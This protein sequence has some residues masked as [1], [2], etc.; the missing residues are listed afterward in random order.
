[1]YVHVSHEI[2]RCCCNYTRVNVSENKAFLLPTVTITLTNLNYFYVKIFFEILHEN[3]KH[4]L[5]RSS[6]NLLPPITWRESL[7]TDH[8]YNRK[9]KVLSYF[10]AITLAWYMFCTCSVHL[11][12]TCVCMTAT[13]WWCFTRLYDVDDMRTRWHTASDVRSSVLRASSSSETY[14][15]PM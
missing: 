14:K 3:P 8:K 9:L 1:M 6:V 10:I 13:L 15:R 7:Y 4:Q 5:P 2:Q 11:H 12:V